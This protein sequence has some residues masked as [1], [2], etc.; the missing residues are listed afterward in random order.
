M[1]KQTD[2]HEHVNATYSINYYRV[3]TE[4]TNKEA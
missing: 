3:F 2:N 1:D 4:L